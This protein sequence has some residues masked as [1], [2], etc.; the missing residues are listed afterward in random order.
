MYDGLIFGNDADTVEEYGFDGFLPRPE[1]ER[2]VAERT[3]IRVED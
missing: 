3:I 1:R 2:K